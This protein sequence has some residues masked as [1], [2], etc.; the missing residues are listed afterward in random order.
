MTPTEKYGYICGYLRKQS[1]MMQEFTSGGRTM[2]GDAPDKTTNET[3]RV[4]MKN[5]MA[6]MDSQVPKTQ[7]DEDENMNPASKGGTVT[8]GGL[9]DEPGNRT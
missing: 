1:D 5:P 3:D 7:D 4:F 2:T 6:G 8:G 9:N